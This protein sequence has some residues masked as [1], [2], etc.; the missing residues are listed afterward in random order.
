MDG[1]RDKSFKTGLSQGLERLPV[2]KEEVAELGGA[3]EDDHEENPVI[4]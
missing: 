2:K 1:H 3:V 4:L